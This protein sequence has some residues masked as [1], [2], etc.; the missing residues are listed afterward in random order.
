MDLKTEFDYPLL[1]PFTYAAKGQEVLAS[2]VK[3]VAPTSRHSRE[4]AALKQA[5]F[6][7]IPKGEE[8]DVDPETV[9]TPSG[10]DIITMIAC[11]QDVDLPDV[12]DTAARLFTSGTALVD[13]ETKLTKPLLDKMSQEDVEGMAGD[14]LANFTVASALARQS[15]N[16]SV[17]S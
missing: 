7:A 1:V 17:G 14:Y 16:S 6:R 2:F 11:S 12:L 10:T 15:K 9:S 13:G 8:T 5:F 4:C 3:L